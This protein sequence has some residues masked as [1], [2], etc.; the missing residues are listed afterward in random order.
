MLDMGSRG[1]KPTV[2]VP[3]ELLALKG[4]KGSTPAGSARAGRAASVGGGHKSV[5]L[6]T[7]TQFEP[8]RGS[9]AR[10]PGARVEYWRSRACPDPTHQATRLRVVSDSDNTV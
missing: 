2:T 4:P 10:V 3:K 5:P 8:L 9:S 6:P 7:A 1:V